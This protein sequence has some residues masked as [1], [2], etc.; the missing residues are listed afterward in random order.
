M[1]INAFS[2]VCLRVVMLLCAAPE[3]MTFTSRVVAAEVG[4]PY[5]HVSKALLRLRQLGLVEAIRG[6]SGGVRISA[7]GREATVGALL[8]QLDTRTDLAACDTLSGPCPLLSGCGLRGALRRARE[9]FYRE[10]DDLVIST[11]PHGKPDGPVLA[12]LGLVR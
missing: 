3:S 1:R 8:R 12:P 5:N 7:L 11:L 10:L 4:T 9:S 6:R 2:D